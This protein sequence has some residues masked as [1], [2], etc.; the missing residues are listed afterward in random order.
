MSESYSLISAK[1]HYLSQPVVADFVSYL[2]D[3]FCGEIFDPPYLTQ[4]LR[5]KACFCFTSLQD[6]WEQYIQMAPNHEFQERLLAVE[7]SLGEAVNNRDDDALIEAVKFL[8][9]S[10]SL[11][12]N[13]NLPTLLATKDLTEGVAYACSQLGDESPDV[14]IFGRT[15]G[16]RMSS[17]LSRIYATLIPGF[18]TYESRVSA[19][20]CYFIREFCRVRNLALPADLALGSLQGWGKSKKDTGRD[21]S[22]GQNVFPRLDTIKKRPMRERTFARS[23]VLA[24]WLV[25]EAIRLALHRQKGAEWL[26]GPHPVR[27]IEGAFYMLGAQLP[28]V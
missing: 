14:D 2:A 24:T 20:L 17:F 28:P 3:Y 25:G 19:A 8:F 26:E 12:L 1:D 27:K 15:F 11:V 22:W 16:P 6:A 7:A 23:N 18:L 10:E 9:S 21:A 4:T 13:S 5:P